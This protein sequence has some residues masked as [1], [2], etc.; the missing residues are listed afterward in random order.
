[1]RLRVL[2]GSVA[3][4]LGLC[5]GGYWL[6]LPRAIDGS[7]ALGATD[8]D[9]RPLE[10]PLDSLATHARVVQLGGAIKPSKGRIEGEVRRA[11]ALVPAHVT[12]YEVGRADPFTNPDWMPETSDVLVPSEEFLTTTPVAIAEA[13][14]VGH[15]G[16]PDVP[17]GTYDV[18]AHSDAGGSGSARVAVPCEGALTMARIELRGGGPMTLAGH[19]VH[20]DGRPFRGFAC[21]FTAVDDASHFPREASPVATDEDGR[22]TLKGLDPGPIT[23]L[24]FKPGTFVARSH[25]VVLP[26]AA[27]FE[28][29]V[30]ASTHEVS[31]RVVAD[32]DE[33]PVAGATVLTTLWSPSGLQLIQS[34]AVT[35]AEGRF[36][37]AALSGL[38]WYLVEAP[39]FAALGVNRWLPEG[40][41]FEFRLVKAGRI[42]GRVTSKVDGSPVEGVPVYAVDGR[43]RPGPHAV[44]KADGRY[45]LT[46]VAP[47]DVLVVA[48]GAGYV[49]EGFAKAS[50]RYNP[51]LI[52][53]EPGATATLDLVVSRAAHAKGKVLDVTGKPVAGAKVEWTREM[54][55][56]TEDTVFGFLAAAQAV[57]TTADGQFVIGT[58]APAFSY[59][60]KASSPGTSEGAAGPVRVDLATSDE[61][62]IRLGA[63]RFAEVLVRQLGGGPIAGVNAY[64]YSQTDGDDW[65]THASG[66]TDANG[67]ARL[68]P[69]PAGPLNIS[70]WSDG[71]R[72]GEDATAGGPEGNTDLI[73]AELVLERAFAVAGTVRYADDSP[74]AGAGLELEGR[75]DPSNTDADAEGNFRFTGLERET[76]ELRVKAQ[77]GGE[78]IQTAHVEAGDEHVKI[79]V[80]VAKKERLLVHVVD[81]DGKA[82]AHA[83]YR[84]LSRQPNGSTGSDD[85]TFEEGRLSLEPMPNEWFLFVYGARSAGGG[86]L[87]LGPAV[88]GPFAAKVREAEV[89]LPPGERI[90][91]IVK[92]PDG[93]G[94]RGVRVSATFKDLETPFNGVD[95]EAAA[96]RTDEHG[97]F[98]L[99]GLGVGAYEVRVTVGGSYGATEPVEAKSGCLDL[100]LTLTQGDSAEP[101]ILDADGKPVVGAYVKATFNDLFVDSDTDGEG[102][103]VL[104]G[105]DAKVGYALMIQPPRSRSDVLLRS[106]NPWTPSSDPITLAR[107]L[108]LSGMVQ[109]A[110]GRPA[111]DAEVKIQCA[112]GGNYSTNASAN[113]T[114]EFRRVPEGE[115]TVTAQI[116]GPPKRF[117]RAIKALAGASDV[118]VKLAATSELIVH[119]EASKP[120][121]EDTYA[122]VRET[123][124][125]ETDWETVDS[126]GHATFAGLKPDGKYV[127]SVEVS[128][129]G[130]ASSQI[131]V[132]RDV[133]GDAKTLELKLTSG[134]SVTGRIRLPVGATN[135]RIVATMD[136]NG[137]GGTVEEDGRYTVGGLTAGPCEVSAYARSADGKHLRAS[138]TVEAG[139]TVDLD[140][141]RGR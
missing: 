65:H 58:L 90:E 43:D 124:S 100:V 104:E 26:S 61:I 46:D 31:G 136:G 23:V 73:H 118:V 4:G 94:V 105:L 129:E 132:A 103:A 101:I 135:V 78:V 119:I 41:G 25:V 74:F 98:K 29:V 131:G 34:R 44:S 89:R 76:F 87:A 33:Q 55:G 125:G 130:E 109:D 83:S 86:P 68:G 52:P 16:F 95:L 49:V 50:G 66:L 30:D 71:F 37:V 126:T 141:D 7:L 56:G 12:L 81:G 139:G 57:A 45:E 13:D 8:E 133:R 36:K 72:A 88:A 127:V 39:G 85:G 138:A 48:F 54:P 14:A 110:D 70:A 96:A 22:F 38:T 67:I 2:F 69:L 91:G 120:I 10:G 59:R 35:D 51:L 11:G 19:A 108:K 60:F 99:G 21:P 53:L 75:G 64:V 106:I 102:R 3:I 116:D 42:V 15:F 27:E 9:D 40:T 77:G 6:T 28:I 79:V 93:H 140:L 114:F 18:V 24:V 117:A 20:A 63:A 107:G 82:V 121:P 92:A 62:E 122:R 32:K 137:R 97:R 115:V 113:G 17:A 112:S 47:G 128:F 5:A 134:L 111:A 84:L 1:M 123:T 80:K